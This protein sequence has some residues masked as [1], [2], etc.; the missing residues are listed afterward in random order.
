MTVLCFGAAFGV[1]GRAI[2][3]VSRLT[4]SAHNL[5]APSAASSLSQAVTQPGADAG[6]QDHRRHPAGRQARR[7]QCDPA[8]VGVP[9][10]TPRA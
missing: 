3:G 4:T 10:Q 8:A 7:R 5:P 6:E 9:H 2:H 1:P